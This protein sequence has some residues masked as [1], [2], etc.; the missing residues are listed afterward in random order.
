GPAHAVHA[1]HA[2][3]GL[4]RR[5]GQAEE[6]RR[7]GLRAGY[8]DAAIHYAAQAGEFG[9]EDGS[10]LPFIEELIAN[11]EPWLQSPVRR[12]MLAYLSSRVGRVDA[13]ERLAG[14]LAADDFAGLP[15]DWM[16]LPLMRLLCEV[17]ARLDRGDWAAIVY[18][19]LT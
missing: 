18:P 9:P 4:R 1:R 12:A 11:E 8:A 10:D 14:G 2:G 19:M 7:Q 5:A 6:A 15:R 13:A 3:G 17:I 16:W